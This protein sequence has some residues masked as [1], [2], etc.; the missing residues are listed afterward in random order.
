[1]VS[2]VRM[3]AGSSERGLDEAT[4]GLEVSPRLQASS[5]SLSSDA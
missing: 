5:W 2:I 3:R 1:M 4:L